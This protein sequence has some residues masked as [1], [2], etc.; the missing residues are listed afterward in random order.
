MKY[1]QVRSK[2]NTN[3]LSSFDGTYCRIA[4]NEL[5]FRK[6][7][8]RINSN[9]IHIGGGGGGGFLPPGKQITQNSKTLQAITLKLGDFSQIGISKI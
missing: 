2:K 3:I 7:A 5:V 4:I 6:A 8:S 1:K 9:P